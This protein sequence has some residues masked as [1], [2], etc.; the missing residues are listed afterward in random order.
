MKQDYLFTFVILHYQTL[1]DTLKCVDSILSKINND[2]FYIVIVDNK[3][4]NNSGN[5]LMN[6]F[7]SHPQIKIILNDTNLGF[8]NGNNVGFNFAKKELKSNFIALINNDTFIDQ[9]DFI[10][11][12]LDKYEK[13]KFHI[14]GPDIISTITGKHQNPT[15][16]TLQNK[17]QL[18]KY[19][20]HYKMLLLLN[21]FGMD[22]F[23]ETAKKQ[24][25]QKPFV[26]QEIYLKYDFNK[27]YQNIKL[28]GSALVFSPLYIEN[29]DGLN[30][31]TFMYSE[32]AILYYIAKR[33]KLKT[34]YFPSVRIFHNEDSATNSLFN[35]NYTKRRFYYKNFIKSGKVLL[36]IMNEKNT[37]L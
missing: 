32:E 21:Y 20:K 6:K 18:K 14:L 9:T 36:N 11:L 37:I 29:Y 26:A 13:S 24:I 16:P 10:N 15:P 35:K 33:D 1:Q 12:I 31:N 30:P 7:S 4:P 28:H 25:I 2:K 23:L 22:K 8:A 19:L 34:I 17:E 27:E 5:E 3:S